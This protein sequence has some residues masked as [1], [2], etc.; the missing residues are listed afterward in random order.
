MQIRGCF[1]LLITYCR[2]NWQV[3]YKP[4]FLLAMLLLQ[5]AGGSRMEQFL[6]Q[7]LQNF[8]E[9]RSDYQQ[10]PTPG[11][12][13][14]ADEPVDDLLLSSYQQLD[15]Q[16]QQRQH[17]QQHLHHGAIPFTGS[18]FNP[19]GLPAEFYDVSGTEDD[20]IEEYMS[21]PASPE[22]AR[23]A[24]AAAAALLVTTPRSAVGGLLPVAAA[25]LAGTA[26]SLS[27]LQPA[28]EAAPKEAAV[29]GPANLEFILPSPRAAAAEG[30]LVAEE[31][32]FVPV[33][34]PA[35]DIAA[36]AAA[37]AATPADAQQ[38]ELEPATEAAEESVPRSAAAEAAASTAPPF[39]MEDDEAIAKQKVA[40]QKKL[41]ALEAAAAGGSEGAAGEVAGQG[42][43]AEE[44]EEMA[45]SSKAQGL[46]THK[47]LLGGA[48]NSRTVVL[49]P[50]QVPA[51]PK[52]WHTGQAAAQNYTPSA[53]QVG[54]WRCVG[55]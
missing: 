25:T 4:V 38:G 11:E 24:A 8:L 32:E 22:A 17:Q 49:D 41:A 2:S 43:V 55:F 35:A 1:G 21:A 16:L 23:A 34:E 19:Q 53:K 7:D 48:S 36:P 5:A 15:E 27:T 9:G 47:D 54:G 12:L 31:V 46:P 14:A 50:G 51:R 20:E 44:E 39:A 26:A 30:A 6:E 13:L 28:A 10:E 45:S 33:S 52:P 29:S 40:A 18:F 37:A 3:G 42:G